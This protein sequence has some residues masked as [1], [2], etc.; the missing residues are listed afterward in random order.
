MEGSGRSPT[1]WWNRKAETIPRPER[2]PACQ[3]GPGEMVATLGR[4]GTKAPGISPPTPTQR[5]LCSPPVLAF[6]REVVPGCP[7]PG[8]S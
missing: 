8:P 2:R 1:W 6:K 3:G 4:P 5:L 7:K